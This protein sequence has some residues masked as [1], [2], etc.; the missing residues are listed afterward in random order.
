MSE[1]RMALEVQGHEVNCFNSSTKPPPQ[2]K[3]ALQL[4]DDIAALNLLFAAKMPPKRCARPSSTTVASYMFGDASGS[5]FGSSHFI[6]DRLHYLHG[7]WGVNLSMESSNY[8]ELSNLVNAINDAEKKHL[9][10]NMKLFVFTDNF[11]ADSTFHKGTSSSKKLFELTL[12]LQKLQMNGGFSMHM[13][14]VSGRRMMHQGTDGLSRGMSNIKVMNGS[15]MHSH[16][17]LHLNALERQD[18][19]LKAWVSS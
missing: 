7:K 4:H 16:I 12:S 2:V 9:L 11:A 3:I 17:P 19:E 1:I 13:I 6:K 18:T 15:A 14:H 10:L 5:G 8:R